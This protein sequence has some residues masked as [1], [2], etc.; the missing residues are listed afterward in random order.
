MPKESLSVCFTATDK[1]SPI[2][3]SITDKTKALDK[4]TQQL[5]DIYTRHRNIEGC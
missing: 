4:E 1:L 3:A 2:L 5:Q